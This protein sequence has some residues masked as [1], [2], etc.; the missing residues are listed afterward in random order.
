MPLW[1]QDAI[2]DGS[3]DLQTQSKRPGEGTCQP[4]RYPLLTEMASKTFRH[5]AL[6][7]R[8]RKRWR[9]TDGDISRMASCT[10]G[11]CSSAAVRRGLERMKNKILAACHSF[12]SVLLLSFKIISAGGKAIELGSS[13]VLI[14]HQKAGKCL[15]SHSGSAGGEMHWLPRFGK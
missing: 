5:R 14:L 7:T 9:A 13:G 4:E 3:S 12:G 8:E 10:A 15:I 2:F 6:P 11:K 1:G